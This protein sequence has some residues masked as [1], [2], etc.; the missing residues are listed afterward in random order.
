MNFRLTFFIFLLPLLYSCTFTEDG[1]ITISNL[2]KPNSSGGGSEEE[3]KPISPLSV[4]VSDDVLN[5]NDANVV[6][7]ITPQVDSNN[8]FVYCITQSTCSE[9]DFVEIDRASL[10][11]ISE[12]IGSMSDGIYTIEVKGYLN[13]VY[14]TDS[15]SATFSLD[16]TPPVVGTISL[17]TSKSSNNYTTT[18]ITYSHSDGETIDIQYCVGVSA[19]ECSIVAKSIVS[20]PSVS[21]NYTGLS[22][23]D[24]DIF[25]TAFVS[26]SAGNE[27][28]TSISYEIDTIGPSTPHTGFSLSYT[29]SSDSSRSPDINFSIPSDSDYSST[30]TCLGTSNSTCDVVDWTNAT[31]YSGSYFG[32]L[33][34]SNG[35]Y[36]VRILST[37]DVGNSSTIDFL[38]FDII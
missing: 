1:K 4:N 25:I 14:S 17:G 29:S 26:D 20:D 19:G 8:D 37:D 28:S 6:F 10:S 7:S 13:G 18:G 3:I 27:V 36:F 9:S 31:G 24:G 23:P 11:S 2:G 33:S 32:S 12:Q 35:T 22:M 5:D 16:A 38:S 34:L 30:Y 15:S 21:E